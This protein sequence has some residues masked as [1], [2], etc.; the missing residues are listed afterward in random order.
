MFIIDSVFN[1]TDEYAINVLKGIVNYVQG[2][3][4]AA[5]LNP[6]NNSQLYYYLKECNIYAIYSFDSFSEK[7]LISLNKG[8]NK[9]DVYKTIENCR[10]FSIEF[11]SN[12]I[13]GA[14]GENEKTIYET[15]EFANTFLDK[16]S[17]LV[18]SFGIRIIPH[19]F[20]FEKIAN[21]RINYLEPTFLYFPKQCFE[22]YYHF[23]DKKF[24]DVRRFLKHLSLKNNYSKI[25]FVSLESKYE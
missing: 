1:R 14:L 21:A 24:I 10:K 11:N 15:C 20:L 7:I 5:F 19:S 6:S 8:F 4:I 23:I 16:K 12:I 13:V 22:Y 9:N 18:T 3:N 25:Q 17:E 2:M